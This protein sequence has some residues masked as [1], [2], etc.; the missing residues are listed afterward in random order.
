MN[1]SW[2]LYF[3]ES[4]FEW[5]S[6]VQQQKRK[7]NQKNM[8]EGKCVNI[9]KY[10]KKIGMRKQENSWNRQRRYITTSVSVKEYINIHKK[11]KNRLLCLINTYIDY[12]LQ[13]LICFRY[14]MLGSNSFSLLLFIFHI[15][16]L[17][18]IFLCLFLLLYF[19]FTFFILFSFFSLLCRRRWFRRNCC[20]NG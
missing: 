14:R 20:C 5:N 8:M 4:Y 16:F 6:S 13:I 10:E 1:K 11:H 19:Y 18:H 2:S 15:Q 17:Q 3:Y 12:I 7:K 9:K